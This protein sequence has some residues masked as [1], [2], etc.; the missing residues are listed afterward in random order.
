MN[1]LAAQ[2]DSWEHT[3][4][5]N[6]LWWSV[7]GLSLWMLATAMGAAIGVYVGNRLAG[8]NKPSQPTA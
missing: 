4:S 8:R 7:F 3:Q 1:T 5:K 2:I 6:L